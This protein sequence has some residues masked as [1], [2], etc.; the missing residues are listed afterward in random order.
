MNPWHPRRLNRGVRNYLIIVA[1]SAIAGAFVPGPAQTA[2]PQHVER[3]PLTHVAD[4]PLPGRPTRLD[5]ESYD[6][7]R[8]LLF[9]SHLGDG[10][11]IVEHGQPRQ[12]RHVPLVPARR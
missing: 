11:V 5:Y 3:L 4:I 7:G 12:L 9:M 10:E 8:H 1:L 2:P 6:P